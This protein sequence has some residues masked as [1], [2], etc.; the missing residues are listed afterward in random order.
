VSRIDSRDASARKVATHGKSAIIADAP[1]GPRVHS[2]SRGEGPLYRQLATILRAPIASGDLAP[3]S[4]LP[5]EADLAEH[6]GVSLITVRHALRELENDGLIRKRAAK[7]AVVASPDS[8]LNS[9]VAFKSFAEIAASAR[10]RR[11][12]IHSYKKERSVA[13]CKA[14]S[15]AADETAYCL[16]ATLFPKNVPTNFITFYFPPIVGARLKRTDFD[17]VVVF[18]SVQRHLGIELSRARITVRAEIASPSLARSLA[19]EEGGPVLVVEM[20]YFSAQGLP[21]ELTISRNRADLFS[22]SYEAPNDLI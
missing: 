6:Y 8:R 9:G 18:R 16:R 19:Y 7:Q 22:L 13:A 11:L 17:D 10:D 4:E 15:L 5:R 12:E 21:I 1:A 20:L 14:F 2:L 3:G